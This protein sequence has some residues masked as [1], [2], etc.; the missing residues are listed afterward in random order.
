MKITNSLIVTRVTVFVEDKRRLDSDVRG[1]NPTTDDSAESVGSGG[2]GEI[3][4]C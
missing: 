4:R 3:L 1:S 2:W